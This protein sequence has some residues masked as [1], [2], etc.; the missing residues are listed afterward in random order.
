M[1]MNIKSHRTKNIVR[2]RSLNL[3]SVS[4]QTNG[5]KFKDTADSFRQESLRDLKA[6]GF[7]IWVGMLSFLFLFLDFTFAIS[8]S[9]L[10]LTIFFVVAHHLQSFYD[11]SR[12]GFENFR[13]FDEVLIHI[14]S[15]ALLITKER[16]KLC[17][18]QLLRYL[19]E[20]MNGKC[21]QRKCN[22]GFVNSMLKKYS[23]IIN[24]YC[25]YND[26]ILN[27]SMLKLCDTCET[28]QSQ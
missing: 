12:S 28:Y 17:T 8:L 4:Q 6:I 27:K 1:E 24:E 15:L 5:S 20:E 2:K 3:R 11:Y 16:S 13:D 22:T 23:Y 26:S 19:L 25:E 7:A 21:K 9:F 10:T 18:A 14:E